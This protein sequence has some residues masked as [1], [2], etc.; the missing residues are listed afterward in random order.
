MNWKLFSLLTKVK[1]FF[2]NLDIVSIMCLII[3]QNPKATPLLS[4]HTFVLFAILFLI[5]IFLL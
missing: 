5:I 4:I 3:I 1:I 2:F